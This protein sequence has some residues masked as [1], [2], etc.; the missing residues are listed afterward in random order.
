[1]GEG[2]GGG[3][4]SYSCSSVHRF[5]DLGA[6]HPLQEREIGLRSPLPW[7]SH[8]NDNKTNALVACLSDA[9]PY[10]VDAGNGRPG[11]S[12]LCPGEVVP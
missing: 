6:R 12:I 2:G 7:S 8:A 4:W 5:S 1:M 11:V 9:I 10:R 3:R